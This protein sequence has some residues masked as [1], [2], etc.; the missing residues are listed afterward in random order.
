MRLILIIS[1]IL[2]KLLPAQSNFNVALADNDIKPIK[3]IKFYNHLYFSVLKKLPSPSNQLCLFSYKIDGTK[4]FETFINLTDGGSAGGVF[5]SNDNKLIALGYDKG[6]HVPMNS[7]YILKIDTNGTLLNNITFTNTVTNN[8]FIDGCQLSNN[9]YYIISTNCLLQINT[10]GSLV[11]SINFNQ[12]NSITKNNNTLILNGKLTAGSVVSNY[13]YD[14][15]LALINT[16]TVSSNYSYFLPKN[17]FYYGINQFQQIDK[18]DANFQIINN[19]SLSQ[20]Y[21]IGNKVTDFYYD[22]DSIYTIGENTIQ[23]NS[24]CLRLDTNLQLVSLKTN[25]TN[26]LHP[27]S[28]VK[29]DNNLISLARN[30]GNVNNAP[31]II[32]YFSINSFKK[33]SI[34]LFNNSVSVT[35]VVFGGLYTI[36]PQPPNTIIEYKL[37]A[38]VK[39]TGNTTINSFVLNKT[40][41]VSNGNCNQMFYSEKFTGLNLG[42]GASITV[43]T[44]NVYHNTYSVATNSIVV[45]CCV[46]ST[47]PND[48]NDFNTSDD[49]YCKIDTV[50]ESL[51]SVNEILNKFVEP[52]IYP[53]P[54]TGILNIE[55]ENGSRIKVINV[56]GELVKEEELKSIKESID[57]S[58]LKNGIYFLQVFDRDKLIAT[59]KI[60]KE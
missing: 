51:V 39:N 35:Q 25:T 38:T 32:N 55:V 4:R 29:T 10:G 22:K 37:I 24:F 33:Y 21:A 49:Y 9:N 56:L 48:K 8:R 27:V 17:G 15:N 3:M 57:I 42:I 36:I 18:M 30:N 40:N 50:L 13:V 26:L 59:T 20:N 1:C 43:T 23:N 12:I 54:T 46:F 34:Y 7:G 52:K 60:I 58:N 45:N 11:G 47:C 41:F 16:Y 44:N 2:V 19:S 14:Q 53:N 6:C 28:V 5:V 31:L